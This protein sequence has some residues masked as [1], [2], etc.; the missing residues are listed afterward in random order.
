MDKFKK[1][2]KWLAYFIPLFIFIVI[3][4]PFTKFNDPPC[5][6]SLCAVGYISIY[7]IYFMLGSLQGLLIYYGILTRGLF[8]L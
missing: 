1:I 7:L 3:Y 8:N 5:P 6:M 2:M 4:I